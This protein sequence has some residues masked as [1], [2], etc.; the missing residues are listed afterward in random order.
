MNG[1]VIRFP[2]ASHNSQLP[3]KK[4]PDDCLMAYE[5]KELSLMSL[6]KKVCLLIGDSSHHNESWNATR[7]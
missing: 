3:F 4:K 5:Q 6:F 2:Y 7:L 1:R